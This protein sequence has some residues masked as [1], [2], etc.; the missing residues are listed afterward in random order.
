MFLEIVLQ[1]NISFIVLYKIE[2]TRS[3][4]HVH[5]F[6][7]LFCVLTKCS[8]RFRVIACLT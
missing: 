3:L 5:N 8:L 7:I 4:L 2:F 6:W 1:F